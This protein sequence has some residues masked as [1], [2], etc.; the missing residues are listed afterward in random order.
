M[1]E[2]DLT[3]N[4]YSGRRSFLGGQ[5]PEANGV[6]NVGYRCKWTLLATDFL[7]ILGVDVGGQDVPGIETFMIRC[8]EDE[9][10]NLVGSKAEGLGVVQVFQEER[11]DF[12]CVECATMRSVILR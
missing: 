10:S 3:I 12:V 4:Y 5:Q 1:F 7:F 11:V 6:S 2:W 9:G 8:L